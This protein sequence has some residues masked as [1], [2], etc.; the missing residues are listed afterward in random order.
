[1]RRRLMILMTMLAAMLA[2]ASSASTFA[3]AQRGNATPQNRRPNILL[4]I[5]DDV[6]M[7]VTTDMYPGLIDDL[8]KNYG[9]AGLNHPSY[10]VINGSP[11]STPN[12]DRLAEQGM[13]F[14]NTWA[15]PFCS[16]TRASILTGLFA[17]KANVLTYA[18][19]LAQTY[20]SF[21][22]KL[23][24]RERLMKAAP[25]FRWPS[26]DHA[27]QLRLATVNMSTLRICSLPSSPSRD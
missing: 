8:T 5:M 25:G 15:Q 24:V 12:L 19:P 17:V 22:Q 3:A 27:F 18:D 6:G 9:P 23:A 14:A 16:P 7:D 21:V 11:A 2:A 26:G 13:V 10:S 4:I 20:T 1:M